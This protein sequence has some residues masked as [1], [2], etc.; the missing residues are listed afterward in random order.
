MDN[1][2]ILSPHYGIVAKIMIQ[3]KHYKKNS[4]RYKLS[5]SVCFVNVAKS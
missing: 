2:K 3:N 4:R 1:K 5:Q